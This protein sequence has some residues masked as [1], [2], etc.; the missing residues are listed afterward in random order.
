[1]FW[2]RRGKF[3]VKNRNKRRVPK[4]DWY[5]TEIEEAYLWTGRGKLEKE[6]SRRRT[7]EEEPTSSKKP[8]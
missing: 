5:E 7:K 1:M 6:R 4:Q 8:L 2:D 3:R